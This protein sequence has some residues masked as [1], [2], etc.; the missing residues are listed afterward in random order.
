MNKQAEKAGAFELIKPNEPED[1]VVQ[2]LQSQK[3]LFDIERRRIVMELDAREH[4]EV[5]NMRWHWSFWILL[6]VIAILVFDIVFVVLV[7]S[8]ILKYPHDWIV[9]VFVVDSLIKV[10]G[11]AMIIVKY[12]FGKFK[13]N[14]NQR[15]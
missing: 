8:G 15:D 3:D 6:C 9:P 10:L 4:V 12:L 1:S 5:M 7:G 2:N 14:G 13:R 11:L